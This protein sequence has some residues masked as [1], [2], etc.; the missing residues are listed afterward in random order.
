[1]KVQFY[2]LSIIITFNCEAQ[3]NA[4]RFVPYSTWTKPASEYLAKR[5]VLDN[6]LG[7]RNETVVFEIDAL[8]S[9][10]STEL[11]T[12]AY[13]CLEL[14]KSGIVFSFWGSFW[15]D[16]GYSMTGY[17]LKHLSL[18]SAIILLKRLESESDYISKITN[19]DFNLSFTFSEMTFILSQLSNQEIGS[20]GIRVFWKDFDAGWN[21]DSIR[22]TLRRIEKWFSKK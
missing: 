13:N 17:G 4:Y 7:A 1:M 8:S 2:L 14:N 5:F 20:I 21:I 6:F 15:N 18:D 16:N 3:V 12:V 9:S 22:R 19:K 11:V 10:A